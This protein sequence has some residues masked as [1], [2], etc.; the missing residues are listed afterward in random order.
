MVE[1]D[2]ASG[3]SPHIC[4]LAHLL[5]A[6]LCAA[7]TRGPVPFLGLCDF[8]ERLTV[9]AKNNATTKDRPRG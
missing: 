7:A 9:Y 3:A 8:V 2:V 1:A 6:K 5:A 4:I